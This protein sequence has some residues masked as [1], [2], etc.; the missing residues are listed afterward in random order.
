MAEPTSKPRV[1]LSI[2][3][4]NYFEHLEG[5]LLFTAISAG[6]GRFECERLLKPSGVELMNLPRSANIEVSVLRWCPA[7]QDGERQKQLLYHGLVSLSAVQ[8]TFSRGDGRGGERDLQ[9]WENWL[10]LFSSDVS[11]KARIARANEVP[12]D[13]GLQRKIP[14]AAAAAAVHAAWRVRGAAG[15]AGAAAVRAARGGRGAGA[16]RGW[17]R[18][19]RG[20]WLPR[21]RLRSACS[22]WTASGRGRLAQ[23]VRGVVSSLGEQQADLG[24][25][26]G[27]PG[28]P[29]G[30]GAP[31]APESD[32]G[33]LR[34]EAEELQAR[35]QE[36]EHE[37][38]RL[39]EHGGG[40]VDEAPLLALAEEALSRAVCAE[41]GLP[42]FDAWLAA[43]GDEERSRL[44]GSGQG[45]LLSICRQVSA[46]RSAPAAAGPGQP[47]GAGRGGVFFYKPVKSDPVDC[48]LA[49][50]LLRLDRE[51]PPALELSRVE[52]GLYRLGASGPRFR[53]HIDGGRLMIQADAPTGG[54][55][56]PPMEFGDFLAAG[57]EALTAA[58]C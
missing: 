17:P 26:A 52:P 9:V 21:R 33:R 30:D 41:P 28:T 53:C 27:P 31:G 46:L 12:G 20:E 35:Y 10:G 19:C 14:A 51:P 40:R 18:G 50:S 11:L 39:R 58:A 15:A 34:R 22:I 25:A 3:K 57:P 23:Q 48:L 36:L 4:C 2:L 38:L 43:L 49:A 55:G 6:F 45:R 56:R 42:S 8:P 29:A 32:V 13:G 7:D 24:E 37:N 1:L 47:P 44:A 5:E 16:A 54:E